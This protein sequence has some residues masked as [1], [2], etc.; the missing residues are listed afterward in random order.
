MARQL[1]YRPCDPALHR[2]WLRYVSSS[3]RVRRP[4]QGCNM[5][6]RD[7]ARPV[8]EPIRPIS[9]PV[10]DQGVFGELLT[11]VQHSRKRVQ[12]C[13]HRRYPPVPPTPAW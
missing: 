6:L 10:A 12:A 2:T 3:S 5:H 1:P 11:A 13:A 9:T 7:P 8:N 4:G